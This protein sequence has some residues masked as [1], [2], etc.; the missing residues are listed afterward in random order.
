VSTTI[1]LVAASAS[2][3]VAQGRKARFTELDAERVNIVDA[4]GRL[5]LAL[6]NTKRMPGPMI[7]GKELAKELS[8]GRTGSAGLIFVDRE[9]NEI[10]GLVYG[11]AVQP[12]G[13]VTADSSLTFD[14]HHQDQV[15]G[16]QYEQNGSKRSYGLNVWDR[17]ANVSIAEMLDAAK[18]EPDR[19]ARHRKFA[20]LL[21]ER[22]DTTGARRVFLGSQD[23]TAA[24]RIMDTSGRERVRLYV[25]DRGAAR[26]EFLDEGGRVV[27]AM[28]DAPPK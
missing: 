17:P 6:A 15:V 19:D 12:D 22:G 20:E 23:R 18:G 14:Q 16:L 5:A 2:L 7:A 4:D 21:K 13:T 11:A 3:G 27:A 24:L 25:D 26:L 8:A 10:G 28:P 9:G 1:A